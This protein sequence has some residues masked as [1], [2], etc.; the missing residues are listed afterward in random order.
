MSHRL[1]LLG[2]AD[3][4]AGHLHI[5]QLDRPGIVQ[6]LV[7]VW[8]VT[9]NAA[10]GRR[11][12]VHADALSDL[13]K[14]VRTGSRV[15]RIGYPWSA[16]GQHTAA[17]QHGWPAAFPHLTLQLIKTNTPTAGL[18]EGKTDL[19]ILRHRPDT[20][21]LHYEVVGEE[22][23]YCAMVSTDPLAHR[24]SVTL[25]QTATLP[26]A[27]DLRTGNVRW[28]EDSNNND[29]SVYTGAAGFGNSSPQGPGSI[30]GMYRYTGPLEYD[31][32]PYWGGEVDCCIN[33]FT[34]ANGVWL[35]A[36]VGGQEQGI[37]TIASARSKR[38]VPSLVQPSHRCRTWKRTPASR[39]RCSHSNR[40]LCHFDASP[41][42]LGI[43]HG[44]VSPTRS[45]CSPYSRPA[46]SRTLSPRA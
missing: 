19:G 10:P 23:R 9:E 22:P 29:F 1:V 33:G 12:E 41:L 42:E 20:K 26:V 7:A 17:F 6:A 39:R 13:E 31:G 36:D 11:L 32:L 40:S 37:R 14:E 35:G 2:R 27:V 4:R 30:A 25:A 43:T 44:I 45:G 46:S 34:V 8:N 15:V 24:K 28:N 3:P 16:L 5:A 38:S 18:L 21:A